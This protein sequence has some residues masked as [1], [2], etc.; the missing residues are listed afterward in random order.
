[1][2]VDRW[3]PCLSKGSIVAR[4]D[5]HWYRLRESALVDN[6]RSKCGVKW[7]TWIKEGKTDDEQ[8]HFGY[9]RRK[10]MDYETLNVI[11]QSTAL[12]DSST[13]RV[14]VIIW[15]G[16][17]FD[18]SVRMSMNTMLNMP[19]KTRSLASFATSDPSPIPIPTGASLSDGASALTNWWDKLKLKR[20]EQR[21]TDHL[22]H[23]R[24][25]S[26]IIF[27]ERQLQSFAPWSRSSVPLWIHNAYGEVRVNVHP[28]RSGR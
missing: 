6:M 14:K 22:L 12:C 18:V 10:E 21:L 27:V 25:W 11:E 9:V 28:D 26:W 23:R 8:N 19:V 13:N 3:S 20:K 2:Q 7:R 24:S 4:A 17:Y 5:I 1:M 16:E 15:K